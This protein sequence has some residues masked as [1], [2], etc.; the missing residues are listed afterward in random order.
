MCAWV[1]VRERVRET[2]TQMQGRSFA[3]THT[4]RIGIR[5]TTRTQLWQKSFLPT[6]HFAAAAGHCLSSQGEREIKKKNR[7]D[8]Q[9]SRR[10]FYIVAHRK[11]HE[12][13][14]RY[15]ALFA[16][17]T[18]NQ[19]IHKSTEEIIP[20]YFLHRF[21]RFPICFGRVFLYGFLWLF[22]AILMTW[23]QFDVLLIN[24]F[25]FDHRRIR[26]TALLKK[27][28]EFCHKLNSK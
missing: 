15:I 7:R 17:Q 25:A 24:S 11:R 5:Y 4:E 6:Y 16:K 12:T 9:M 26:W 10:Y 1:R 18:K 22:I 8:L 20:F 2:D 3:L 21:W 13:K 27:I 23:S 28:Y 19:T 14:N